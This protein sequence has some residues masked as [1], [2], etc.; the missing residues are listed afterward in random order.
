MYRGLRVLLLSYFI[1]HIPI[2]LL[3]DAQIVFG[4][5]YPAPLQDVFTWY[6]SSFR[7]IVL[8]ESGLW[9]KSF[10][11]AEIIF[12]LPFFFYAVKALW[13]NTERDKT[14]SVYALAYGIHVATTVL[15][16]MSTILFSDELGNERDRRLILI[17]IYAP[18]FL[19]PLLVAVEAAGNLVESNRN[20]VKKA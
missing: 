2:T 12:Q 6:V 3:I 18:Y 19:C 7:D 14:Y 17:G 9:L 13:N 5:L 15:P 16:I 11:Y 20:N 4:S 10:I 8:R 1:S